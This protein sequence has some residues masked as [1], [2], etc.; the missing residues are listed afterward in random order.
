MEI[1]VE[2]KT[3]K[4]QTSEKHFQSIISSREYKLKIV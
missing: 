1:Q 4:E 2:L 3:V